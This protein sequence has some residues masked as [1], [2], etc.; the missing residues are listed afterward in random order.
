M[1]YEQTI[2]EV[3]RSADVL[4]TLHLPEY[5]LLS[6][7][8]SVVA[9]AGEKDKRHKS[10]L[11]MIAFDENTLT[12]QRKYLLI[13]DD[14][15]GLLDDPKKYLSID[16]EMVLPSQVLTEPYANEN[17]RRIAILRSV[18]A[19]ALEDR[20]EVGADNKLV[21]INGMLI[22]QALGTVLIELDSSPAMASKL[23]EI[24]GVEFDHLNLGKGR[25]QMVVENYIVKIRM[26]LG[27]AAKDF[28]EPEESEQ[29]NSKPQLI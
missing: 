20:Q 19:A 3:S 10:W 16:C 13:V 21:N 12:A 27:S 15:P 4:S 11:K 25:I 23:H 1:G 29:P 22:T 18:K 26:R 24:G 9:C 8:Q 7:S 2:L 5:E 6:T 14:T 17:A 28:D